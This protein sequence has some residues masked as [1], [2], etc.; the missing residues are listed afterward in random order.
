MENLKPLSALC[1]TGDIAEN[2]RRWKQ[3]WDLYSK[4]SGSSAKGKDVQCAI[5]LHMIGE[6][7][8]NIYDTFTFTE[9]EKDKVQPL[10][11]KFENYFSP[12][13]NITYQR[14]LFNTCI[15]NGRHFDIFLVDLQNKAKFCEFGTLSDS[16]IRDRIVC[17][18][19][20]KPVRER[21]LRDNEL[22]LTKAI[23]LVRACETSKTQVSDLEGN[24]SFC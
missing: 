11:N 16:L 20:A 21:L 8:L 14:Y 5:L 15:Q 12:K 24:N 2:W 1:L 7:A 6:E 4:A 13:K 19:D 3:R 17:G 23:N 10:I 9:T 18:I 22:T